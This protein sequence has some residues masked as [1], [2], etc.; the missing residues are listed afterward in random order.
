MNWADFQDRHQNVSEAFEAFACQ[1]FSRWCR[2]KY[3]AQLKVIYYVGGDGGD[4][5]VE[6]FAELIDESIIGL[7]AKWF[8][9]TFD[10][11]QTKQ[12]KNSL[13]AAKVRFPKLIKYIVCLPI[14]LQ[15]SRGRGNAG[16]SQIDRWRNFVDAE[17]L[18]PDLW[19]DRRIEEEAT[20]IL[21]L[22]W[23]GRSFLS[24]SDWQERHRRTVTAWFHDRYIP[25]LHVCGMYDATIKNHLLTREIRDALAN[26]VNG[27]A[28]FLIDVCREMTRLPTLADWS[29]M[30]SGQTVLTALPGEVQTGDAL[31]RDFAF[32]IRETVDGG[33]LLADQTV[34]WLQRF[35]LLLQKGIDILSR[36][37]PNMGLSPSYDCM[38]RM[39][40]VSKIL[41]DIHSVFETYRDLKLPL[42]LLGD[43]GSGKTHSVVNTATKRLEGGIPALVIPISGVDIG[44]PLG[45]WIADF[46]DQPTWGLDD[47]FTAMEAA[48]YEADRLKAS[49]KEGPFRF[50][51]AL[52]GLEE[53]PA[54]GNWPRV[55]GELC[56]A[57]KGYSR[58]TVVCAVRSAHAQQCL[59]STTLFLR[60]QFDGNTQPLHILFKRYCLQYDVDFSNQPW[61]QWALQSPLDIRLFAQ[62]YQGRSLRLGDNL[63]ISTAPLLSAMIERLET[64][65]RASPTHG[66]SNN[67]RVFLAVLRSIGLHILEKGDTKIEH[68]K[69]VAIIRQGHPALAEFQRKQINHII[70]GCVTHGLLTRFI[71]PSESTLTTGITCYSCAYHSISDFLLANYAFDRIS[72]LATVILKIQ[73][74]LP[75]PLLRFGCR[76]LRVGNKTSGVFGQRPN[77]LTLLL[78]M[79]NEEKGIYATANSVFNFSGLSEGI[80]RDAQ[81]SALARSLREPPTAVK[82]W[83]RMLFLR[84]MPSNRRVLRLLIVPTARNRQHWCGGVFANESLLPLSV[85]QRD[86]IWSG[87]D[88]LPNTCNAPWEGHG[89][90]NLDDIKLYGGDAWNGVPLL[91]AWNC[92][93]VIEARVRR[94]RTRLAKWG[95]LNPNEMAFFI[96]MI[97]NVNDPQVIENVMVAAAG[98]ATVCNDMAGLAACAVACHDV[99]FSKMRIFHTYNAITRHAARVIIER[100]ALRHQASAEVLASARP[101]YATALGKLM[102]FEL[103]PNT[104]ELINRDLEW[105][106]VDDATRGFFE[107]TKREVI[108]DPTL[109]KRVPQAIV[110]AAITGGIA[111]APSG[112]HNVEVIAAVVAEYRR[113]Q[114]ELSSLLG[115]IGAMIRTSII[116]SPGKSKTNE[117][118]STDETYDTPNVIEEIQ[119]ELT[120]HQSQSVAPPT[121]TP[122]ATA[123]LMQYASLIGRTTITPVELRDGL[124]WTYAKTLGWCP[125]V[126]VGVPNGGKPGE[127]LG[128]DIAIIREHS[129]ATH[130]AHSTV[131]CFG[132]K[133]VWCAVNEIAGYLADRLSRCKD[134]GS[135]WCQVLDYSDLGAGMP[136]PFDGEEETALADSQPS[137]AFFA[138][139][140]WLP[141]IP[142]GDTQLIKCSDW[143]LHAPW[144][145]PIN[146]TTLGDSIVLFSRLCYNE[147]EDCACQLV[148]VSAF[149]VESELVD[150]IKRDL[151]FGAVPVCRRAADGLVGWL[152]GDKC[153]KPPSVACWA[154][155]VD[156]CCDTV[157]YV[158]ITLDGTAKEVEFRLLA[159][160]AHWTCGGHEREYMLPSPIVRDALGIVGSTGGSYRRAYLS[161]DSTQIACF[162]YGHFRVSEFAEMLQVKSA[163]LLSCMNAKQW[164]LGWIVELYRE[165]PPQLYPEKVRQD[166]IRLKHTHVL[167]NDGTNGIQCVW[168]K[169]MERNTF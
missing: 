35:E 13:D 96:K 121:Y 57:L 64:E 58:I 27:L 133:Y 33:T 143:C 38:K 48:A 112:Q 167:L 120:L 5:G 154:P 141:Y 23:F 20:P 113:K 107:D 60:R 70:D 45:R 44:K 40:Q 10:N 104:H 152:S 101:P 158:T 73:G 84:D 63:R 2:N 7:Q 160:K 119:K 90:F 30:G 131:S 37:K 166:W 118:V 138:D 25:D 91:L 105:Y 100:A 110:D 72:R 49:G 62:V 116:P 69:L 26:K 71:S 114:E 159:A 16:V 36:V 43:P 137:P 163:P 139:K 28:N 134:H 162:D 17:T 89:K 68:E 83:V 3:G 18:K 151:K 6:A 135:E 46:L 32:E 142:T 51:F 22:Y 85:A 53:N 156:A 130:G 42:A 41:Q 122:E 102:A 80:I 145:D 123:L 9:D 66:W 65:L 124:V 31:L 157:S 47:C 50:L 4:G 115:S 93:S 88:Y 168:S 59:S 127:I 111:I 1:L 155:W 14:E 125:N 147:P 8:R 99:F 76:L 24:L 21:L 132:E 164:V 52:D 77:A 129:P 39:E 126:F 103:P 117:T 56:E 75:R 106:V 109:E 34:S 95:G 161:A 140:F 78:Q 82:Q 153:Y 92:S 55:L 12:V 86:L 165:V 11:T 108:S 19:G 148:T 150:I 97:A 146:F 54:A 67:D 74:I 81:L 136:D 169:E 98:A 94:C 61:V 15:G 149:A 79:M 128:A 87:P 144:P 29:L